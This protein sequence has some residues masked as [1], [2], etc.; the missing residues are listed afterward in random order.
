MQNIMIKD[1]ESGMSLTEIMGWWFVYCGTLNVDN[2]ILS[3]FPW[4]FKT[5]NLLDRAFWGI[6]NFAN[7]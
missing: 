3:L 5:S 4:K 7:W 2:G 1:L 6:Y